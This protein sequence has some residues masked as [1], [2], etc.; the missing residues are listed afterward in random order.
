[1]FLT[2]KKAAVASAVLAAGALT[3]GVSGIAHADDTAQTHDIHV[4]S[5]SAGSVDVGWRGVGNAVLAEVLVYNAST[6]ALVIHTPRTASESTG[7][8]VPLPADVAGQALDLKVAFTVNGVPT[9]WS[10]P[11]TFYASAAG[12]LQGAAGA[13]GAAGAIGPAGPS[14]VVS[15]HSSD[16]TGGTATTVTTGGP[17][18]TNAKQVGSD[19][20]L[21]A[22]TYLIS[23]SAKATPPSGGTGA[24][25]VFPQFFVYNGTPLVDFSNDLFNVGA[26][27][28]ESGAHDT[29]DS[30]YS[31]AQ[32]VTLAAAGTIKVYAFGYDSDTGSGTYTLDSLN[33][34]IV[35]VTPA[36]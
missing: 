8:T 32:L 21:A 35:Q 3:F 16:L 31:G 29:I 12:G 13:V 19:V 10:Q 18:A 22:G 33:L 24:V 4:V 7:T 26:G 17:F 36:S 9:G 14:G 23:V 15:V 34:S 30:Y 1:M 25:D 6:Q 5:T 20:S 11:V 28:L 27:P 2:K